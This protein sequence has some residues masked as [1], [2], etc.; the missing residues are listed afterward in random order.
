MYKE[1]WA[2]EEMPFET[3]PN[4]RFYFPSLKHEEAF[5]RL[6]YGIKQNK[7]AMMVTG[8]IGCGK[9]LLSR[10]LIQKVPVDRFY[11]VLVESPPS[12]R[13]ELLQEILSQMTNGPIAA[14]GPTA[15]KG[16]LLRQAL[17]QRLMDRASNGHHT[18]IILDEAQVIN[19]REAFEE[20]RLFL[21]FQLE[22]RFLFTLILVGQPE[23]RHK[24][25]LIEQLNQRI[26]VRYHLR[27]LDYEEMV[28]Y[29]DFRLKTAG[30][31]HPVAELFPP[32]ALLL[33]HKHS[34]GIPRKVNNLC[35]LSLLTAFISKYRIIDAK[36]VERVVL[37]QYSQRTMT[38]GV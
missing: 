33:I 12:Q 22:N 11:I 3:A 5:S 16:W 20:I 13:V 10:T 23:L 6:L 31:N 15:K 8:E 2:L 28:N 21:N 36:I 32:D 27:P 14:K 4:P 37:D 17:K 18:V 29:I 35:D 24:I 26:E 1:Y 7:G 9:T 38:H 34:E 19:D 25:T 30:F